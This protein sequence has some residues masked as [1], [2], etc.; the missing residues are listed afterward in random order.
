MEKVVGELKQLEELLVQ[1]SRCGTCQS[2]CP[3]YKKD[4]QESSVARGKMYLLDA[5]VEGQI[6][7]ADEI[8]KYLDYCV[9][10]GR[11]K[12]NCPSGVK[13]DE[14]FLRAR[15]I[16][17]QVKKLP[18]WQK[19]ALKVAMGQPKLLAA[20]SPLFHI[21]LRAGAS[22]VDDG[23][24]KPMGL[25]RPLIGAMADR[26]VIDMPAEPFTKKYGGFNQAQNEKMRVIFYPGCAVTLIYTGWGEAIVE[27]LLHYG[28]SVYVPEVNQCCGIPS[29][30]M[31]EMG[32]YKKQ[33]GVNFDYFDSIKDAEYIL[34]CCPT[35]EYGLG[36]TAERE[37]G[38]QRGKQMM[39]IIVFMAEVLKGDYPK[40]IPLEGRT[41][42]HIPCHYNHAKD[43]VLKEFI[44]E[45]FDTEYADL[46]ND[47]CCGFGGTFS[48]KNYAHTKEISALKAKEVEERGYKNLFTACP[49]C[50]MN[51]TDATLTAE[52]AVQASHPVV[53]MYRRRIKK[54]P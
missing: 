21:G 47:G 39:D 18:A 4:R 52:T 45:H 30:T 11:C 29:A 33:I 53:E 17:R 48:L 24:F 34:T 20:M 16:L 44:K 35:C 38:R 14:I 10:C 6:K 7:K 12:N 46:K 43:S 3:L 27:T 2:V 1:C 22:K 19:L 25:F 32:L 15:G 50:A 41:T 42:L 26:H 9:L 8:Y 13:T 37:S 54:N 31:G 49:G 5:L 23:V 51:L 40:D 36:A 28:V